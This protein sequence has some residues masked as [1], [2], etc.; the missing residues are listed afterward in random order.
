[1][2]KYNQTI[3]E[4]THQTKDLRSAPFC[5]NDN[6]RLGDGRMGLNVIAGLRVEVF[7]SSSVIC[8]G[9]VGLDIVFDK[10]VDGR[11][12]HSVSMKL[13]DGKVCV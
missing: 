11:A 13:P 6:F 3:E 12:C 10:F 8:E 2:D 4:E 1:M 7:Q 5:W 9:V